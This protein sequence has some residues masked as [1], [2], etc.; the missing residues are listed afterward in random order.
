MAASLRSG[1]LSLMVLATSIAVALGVARPAGQVVDT[2]IPGDPIAIESGR[3]AGL[4]LP[5]GI[6]AY[7]GIPYAAPPVR[8]LRWKAPQPV[9]PWKG[10]YYAVHPPNQCMQRASGPMS[11]GYPGE[12]GMS[13]D[14]LYLNVWRPANARAG[15][16]LPVIVFVC[17]GGWVVG[18]ANI[19]TCN[20]EQMARRGLVFVAINYRLGIFGAYA[21]RELSAESSRGTSGNWGML[22]AVAALQ[23]VH[24]NID[25]FGGDPGNVTITGHSF[26][27]QAVS[28]LQTTPLTRGLIHRVFSMS[29]A[30]PSPYVIHDTQEEAERRYA[31]VPAAVGAKSLADLRATPA[32]RLTQTQFRFYDPHVDGY[33]FPEQPRAIWEKGQQNDVPVIL[34]FQHDE[35]NNELRR[36]RTVAEYK[37]VAAKVYGAQVDR[38]L[39][40]YPVTSDAEVRRVAGDVAREAGH[41]GSMMFWAAT[42]RA[43]GKAPVYVTDF[44]RAHPFADGVTFSGGFD[45]K[46]AGAYHGSCIPYW[47]ANLDQMNRIRTTRTWTPWDYEMSGR[48]ADALAAFAKT[49]NPSTPAIQ[50]PEWTVGSPR[51]V[52]FG[53]AIA[54]REA[55][56]DRL[57]FVWSQESTPHHNKPFPDGSLRGGGDVQ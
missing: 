33:F 24:R 39:Q 28:M 54:V 57:E 51:Y 10:V 55:R 25:R 47:F 50:W 14:C 43:K 44:A 30:R 35:D 23:W 12:Q 11:N 36:T 56:R 53:D 5:S 29:S 48:M 3:V 20:G 13:E 2:T 26:G 6:H 34:S 17:G 31:S 8:D 1:S 52:E 41:F 27:G 16:R 37:T 7:L 22:D 49:G 32:D 46:T 9:T 18:S 15:Q 45:P 4:V 19:P 40:L 42:Q 38:F 21:S